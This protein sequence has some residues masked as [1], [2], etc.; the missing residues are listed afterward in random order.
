MLNY[1][2]II[3]SS[4][5]GIFIG[6]A[7]LYAYQI[8]GTDSCRMPAGLSLNSVMNK[9]D[10]VPAV[11]IGSGPAGN[12]AA[13]YLARGGVGR[14][15]VLTGNKPGGLLTE[16]T[17]VENWP[18][19]KKTLGPDI[20]MSSKQQAQNFGVEYVHAMVKSVDIANWPF[21]IIMDNGKVINA[22]SIVIATG[23][24]PRTLKIKGESKYWGHGVTTCAKC[25]APFFKGKNVVVVGGGDSAI[26]E[27]SILASYANKV[28]VLVRKDAMRAT[29]KGQGHLKALSNVEI[30][31]NRELKEISGNQNDPEKV[32]IYNNKTKK[33]ETVP[34]DGIF[35]AIGHIPNT[36]V[37]KNSIALDK[38]GYIKVSGRSQHTSVCGV[39]AAGDVED[40]EYKQAGTA[41]GDG[42]KAGLNALDFLFGIGLNK[43]IS[44][45]INHNMM[46]DFHEKEGE[47]LLIKS[48]ADFKR[49]IFDAKDKIVIV[50]FFADYCPSCLQMLP[51]YNKVAALFSGR[52][53]FAKIDIGE[54]ESMALA[55]EYHVEKIPCLLVFKNDASGKKVLAAR[56]YSAMD[57]TELVDYINQ[58][59]D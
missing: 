8:Q 35:Y 2:E 17:W 28:T 39:F 57:R 51:V 12:S 13:L 36:K 5:C 15:I 43:S 31:Y 46:L 45:K 26:E 11:I 29:P 14:V 41:A 1:K 53:K 30:Q 4:V 48:S 34:M 40:F 22:M 21:K 7:S 19:I 44:Q 55:D 49:E 16:T 47:V 50:D 52:V 56:H 6:I 24:S 42:I 54:D 59:V 38:A 27:A 18:G 10:L 37:F 32:V 23:A 58:F 3:I 9:K 20:M 25:D 33:T